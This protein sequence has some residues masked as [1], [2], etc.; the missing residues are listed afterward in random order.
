MAQDARHVNITDLREVPAWEHLVEEVRTTKTPAIIQA[1][2]EDVAELR[3]AK[4]PVRTLKGRPT[5][6]TDPL[7]NIEGIGHSGKHTIARD[8]DR[9]LADWERSHMP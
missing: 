6:P 8:H 5:S 3:P 9:Y 4:R 7:W 1:D 2:G